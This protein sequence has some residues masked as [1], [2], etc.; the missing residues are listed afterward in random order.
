MG[1]KLIDKSYEQIIELSRMGMS[2][3]EIAEASGIDENLILVA[4]GAGDEDVLAEMNGIIRAVARDP[5]AP[6]SV[7][8]KSAIDQRDELLGRNEKRANAARVGAIGLLM[9]DDQ[10][11]RLKRAQPDALQVLNGGINETEVKDIIN[12]R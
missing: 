6:H 1:A 10:L 3:G 7:R 2:A 5:A 4:L 8:V 11:K 12:G 9:L